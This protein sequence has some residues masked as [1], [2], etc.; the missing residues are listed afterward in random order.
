MPF[1][2]FHNHKLFYREQGHGK[3]II[4]L[5]G[6]TASSALHL[7]E[8]EYFGKNFHAVSLDFWGTGQSDRLACWPDNWY[9]ECAHDAAALVQHLDVGKAALLGTS[10]GAW[11]AL[12]TAILHPDKI[13][14]VVADSEV[15]VYPPAL[16]KQHLSTRLER[17]EGQRRFWRDAH[18]PDWEQVVDADT[19]MLN[20]Q[21]DAGGRLLDERLQEITCPVLITAS[22]EDPLLP[23]VARQ[24]AE[25]AN[26]IPDARL[27]LSNKGQHPFMW[28]NPGEF[29][30]ICDWFLK[31]LF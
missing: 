18:G 30:Y 16:L 13:S 14:A 20:R 22:L 12:W 4:V 21:A 26:I 15:M 1:F 6:N 19:D 24:S 10:G 25:M 31:G 17:S 7:G 9:K 28:S 5:P 2:T 29:R 23:D 8:L 27:Y 3:T 11:V